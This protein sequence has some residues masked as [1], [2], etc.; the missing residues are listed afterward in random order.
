MR[1]VLQRR[2]HLLR[3]SGDAGISLAEML[4]AM[5]MFALLLGLTGGFIASAY[6]ASGQVRAID[7]ATRTASAGMAEMTRTLRAATNNPVSTSTLADAAFVEATA[8]AV[9]VYAYVNLTSSVAKPV[10]VRFSVDDKNNLVETQW[11]SV[12]LGKG[13]WGF[14]TAPSSTRVLAA[15]VVPASAGGATS[16]AYV[17]STGAVISL[18]AGSVPTAFVR[19]IAAVTVTLQIGTS[20]GL[21]RS[22]TL[23]N[24]VGLP[25][26]AL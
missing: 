4:V 6:R 10:K 3:A 24:T 25:N 12:D 16:F 9:T 23:T 13:Y 21:D 20:A 22:T 26:I 18:A 19:G 14:Q 8:T 2:L 5:T 11:A 1:G 15:S 17:D 7:G